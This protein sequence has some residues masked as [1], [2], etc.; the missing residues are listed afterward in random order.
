MLSI[1]TNCLI[2]SF[3]G[4]YNRYAGHNPNMKGLTLLLSFVVY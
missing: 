3:Q 4:Y 2:G 1:H